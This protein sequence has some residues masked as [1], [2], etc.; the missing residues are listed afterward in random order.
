VCPGFSVDC[1][2]TLEE[3]A[4]Q[5]REA[6]IEAG[7]SDLRYIPALNA[8]PS[9]I[10]ALCGLIQRNMLG[11]PEISGDGINQEDLAQ[12]AMRARRLGAPA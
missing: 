2:E 6:F 3:I 8:S 12:R 4:I 10:D 7:G 5:N 1:L 9:H 11:W